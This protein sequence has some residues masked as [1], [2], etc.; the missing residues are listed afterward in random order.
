MERHKEKEAQQPHERTKRCL[1]SSLATGQK[2]K[3]AGARARGA[4][5]AGVT[6][7]AASTLPSGARGGARGAV[8]HAHGRPYGRAGTEASGRG[9]PGGGG[10]AQWKSKLGRLTGPAGNSPRQISQGQAPK[11]A[12][13]EAG[14]TRTQPPPP[15]GSLTRGSPQRQNNRRN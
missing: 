7:T 14:T 12:R 6:T 11:I 10:G 8:R 15:H 5:S 1:T 2:G 3:S 9:T 13:E 4:V